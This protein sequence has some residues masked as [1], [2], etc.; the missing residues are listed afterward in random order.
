MTK[1]S[2]IHETHSFFRY[3][4]ISEKM[5]NWGFAVTN[6]GHSNV[7]PGGLYPPTRHPSHH[8]FTWETGRILNSP[9]F[10]YITQGEGLFESAS[11]KPINV[12]AG[13]FFVLFPGIW[14]RYKPSPKTG[15]HEY[16]VDFEGPEAT[17]LFEQARFDMRHPV[18]QIGLDEDLLLTFER[19]IDLIRT[20]P[21]GIDLLLS[22][23][24]IRILCRV[25][26]L[27]EARQLGSPQDAAAISK[28]KAVML[29]DLKA[30][31]DL[32]DVAVS[33]GMSYTSFRRLFKASTGFSP[34]Q[35]QLEHKLHRAQEMLSHSAIPIGELSEA[36]GFDSLYYFSQFFKK[37]TGYSP[38][39]FRRHT[40]HHQS[41]AP[42]QTNPF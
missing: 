16:W 2:D 27:T 26:A 13:D 36:L 7:A 24:V 38:T 19:M 23:E 33:L 37:K 22:S 41:H 4:P 21:F 11:C 25:L 30:N 29:E 40:A 17:H 28:A 9:S 14:H 1:K 35:F 10:I 34:R 20:D 31:A 32:R 8:H 39:D 15:W 42:A 18:L 6:I 5:R 12:S 3:M